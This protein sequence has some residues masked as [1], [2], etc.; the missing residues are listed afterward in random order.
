MTRL[1]C[2]TRSERRRSIASRSDWASERCN[3]LSEYLSRTRMREIVKSTVLP[4]ELPVTA[5]KIR[6]ISVMVVI[7]NFL[8]YPWVRARDT[9]RGECGFCGLYYLH[10]SLSVP[11]TLFCTVHDSLCAACR[12]INI[13]WLEPLFA[14]SAPG[15]DRSQGG[16]PSCWEI[17]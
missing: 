16:V 14:T 15:P 6:P 17:C 12:S 13:S 5:T 3:L 2:R 11:L 7:S 4:V 10:A 1:L 9:C 8:K